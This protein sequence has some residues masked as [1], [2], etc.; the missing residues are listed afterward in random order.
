M[1]INTIAA[2]RVS[3]WTAQVWVLRT[4][5]DVLPPGAEI[6]VPAGLRVTGD[7]VGGETGQKREQVSSFTILACG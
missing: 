7:L 5:P 4:V 2:P 1:A 6:P 3:R